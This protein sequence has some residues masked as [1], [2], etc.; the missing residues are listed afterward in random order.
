MRRRWALALALFVAVAV[1]PF[2][3]A[4]ATPLPA[5]PGCPMF[6]SN[7]VWHADVS[8]MPVDTKSST[9]VSSIGSTAPLHPDFGTVW[10]GAPNGIP[11]DAVPGTQP[12]V[13]VSFDY[14][15]ESDP[16]PYPIPPN[17]QI[18]GGP[19]SNGD[20]HVLVV[21]KDHCNLYEM[22]DAHKQS[23]G[24]WHA[25]SGAVFSMRSNA[26]RPAGWTSADAAGL[27]MLVGLVTYDEVAA[28][29]VDHAIR[30]SVNASYIWPARHQAGSANASRPPM[31]QRFRLKASVD[32]SHFSPANQVILRALKTY[33]AFVADNG[34]SWYISGAPDSRWNDD[35][36]HNLTSLHG[37]DFEAINESSLQISSGSG[38]ARASVRITSPNGGETWARGAAHAITWTVTGSPGT[39]LQIDLWR[40]GAYLRHVA[41]V[42]LASGSYSWTPATTIAAGGGYQVRAYV[43]GTAGPVVADLSDATFTLT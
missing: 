30:M 12:T 43:V 28:G 6:P 8:K 31:G 21:D 3:H 19:N 33:G 32:I 16:G 4:T 41:R 34:S 2:A 25:G 36:L 42:P 38:A 39:S 9:Y 24:S 40:N 23:D 1:L 20:R 27:P 18:E 13:P 37:A 10:N 15:D 7:N 29:L 14:A 11:Y 5:A 26:L 22:F 17:A 35:D